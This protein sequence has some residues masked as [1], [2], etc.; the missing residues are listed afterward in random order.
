[1]PDEPRYTFRDKLILCSDIPNQVILSGTKR[2]ESR[3]GIFYE[4]HVHFAQ[5]GLFAVV[6]GIGYQ[7]HLDVMLP[8][9]DHK[10]SRPCAIARHMID[11]F[12]LTILI[13]EFL[14]QR[15]VD[16]VGE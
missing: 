8:L 10:W 2:L 3:G 1:M 16:R 14:I 5:P 4:D 9:F 12:R 15:E 7:N 13:D 11:P 6:V